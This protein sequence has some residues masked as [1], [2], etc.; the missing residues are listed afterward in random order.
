VTKLPAR[1]LQ[2]VGGELR[3][4]V[5]S[6]RA[7]ALDHSIAPRIGDR[8]RRVALARLKQADA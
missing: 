8:T 6:D 7:Y 1:W 4:K 3:G 5:G 2:T